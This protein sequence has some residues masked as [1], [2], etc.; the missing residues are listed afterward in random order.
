MTEHLPAIT[1]FLALL[2]VIYCV[3]DGRIRAVVLAVAGALLWWRNR[4]RI[5]DS[6]NASKNSNS[7]EP[8]PPSTE[9]LDAEIADTD[10]RLDSVDDTRP[11][12]RVGAALDLL[13]EHDRNTD[14]ERARRGGG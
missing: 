4:Q 10:A 9:A 3:R 14:R 6:S 11:S 1:V 2:V 8:T 7:S 13:D 5:F 12:G